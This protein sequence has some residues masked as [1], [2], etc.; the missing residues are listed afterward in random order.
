MKCFKRILFSKNS[1]V[2]KR[3]TIAF[4]FTAL[5]EKNSFLLF[6]KHSKQILYGM[7]N[8][9]YLFQTLES[10]SLKI[11]KACPPFRIAD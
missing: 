6:P 8:Q 3:V 9:Y 7:Q 4:P 1:Q 5:E 11:T 10:P 2:K